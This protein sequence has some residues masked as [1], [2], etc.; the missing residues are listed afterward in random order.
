MDIMLDNDAPPLHAGK[1]NNKEKESGRKN[2]HMWL[3]NRKVY[4]TLMSCLNLTNPDQFP[5][6]SFE[7]NI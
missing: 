3:K 4:Y 5:H 6:Y 2:F 1:P 7:N